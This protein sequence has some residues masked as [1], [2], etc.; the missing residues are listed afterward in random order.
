MDDD[1][2]SMVAGLAGLGDVTAVLALAERRLR[3]G[4]ASFVA[5]LGIAVWRSYGGDTTVPWQHRS[6]FD[7]TLRLLTLTPGAIDQAV[8]LI[9]VVQDR[10]QIRYAASLLA[11]AHTAADLAAVFDADGSEELRAC[12]LQELVLRG[13]EVH[14]RWVV[15]PHRRQ[16]PLGW[17]PLSLTPIEGHP[18]R[19]RY[20]HGGGSHD[21]PAMAAEPVHGHC[22]VPR[23]Q[24]TTTSGE[25]AALS[26]AVDNWATGSNGRIEAQTFAFDDDLPPDA[27]GDALVSVDLECTLGLTTGLGTCSPPQAWRQLF[28]AASTGGAYNRGEFG[29]YGRLLAW[30]SVAALVGAANGASAGDVEALAHRCSWYSFAG[31]TAWFDR[32]A[33]DIGLAVVS[34]D[35]RRLAVLAASD[36]D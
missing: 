18:S 10:R 32:I 22:P 12:L 20:H 5:D 15:S 6:V 24:E 29:A 11:S 7:R 17:L 36:T 14:H 1:P 35:R 27:V 33:W 30:R 9:A 19:P 34:P 25:A 28:A 4:D 26:A 21:L 2:R 13:A 31:A 3:T 23:W 16:H 8:R